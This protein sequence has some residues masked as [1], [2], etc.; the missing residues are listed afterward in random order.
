MGIASGAALGATAT[1]GGQKDIGRVCAVVKLRLA[2]GGIGGESNG[3][4]SVIDKRGARTDGDGAD[5]GPLA[6]KPLDHAG[7]HADGARVAI[8]D[9]HYHR[10]FNAL[11][12]KSGKQTVGESTRKLIERFVSAKHRKSSVDCE[13][14]VDRLLTRLLQM[15]GALK[16]NWMDWTIPAVNSND[17]GFGDIVILWAPTAFGHQ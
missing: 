13:K 6:V 4:L 5:L 10:T 17:A 14:H 7:V 16:R 12:T 8:R 1:T 15:M 2:A 3:A 11:R 9:A